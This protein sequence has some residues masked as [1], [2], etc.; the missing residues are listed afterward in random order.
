MSWLPIAVGPFVIALLLGAFTQ[1]RVSL[2]LLPPL[3]LALVYWIGVGGHAQTSEFDRG[4][5][6][7]F[8][9]VIG[10]LFVL[11]WLVCVVAGRWLRA[12]ARE[13]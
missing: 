8:T 5:L 12:V 1:I 9:G 4:G 2:L 13:R 7:L 3:V 10:A 11:I 6:L